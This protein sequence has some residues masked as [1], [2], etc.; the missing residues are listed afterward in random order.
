MLFDQLRRRDF[1][2]L[3]GGAAAAWPLT[4]HAQQAAMPGS[5]CSP[6]HHVTPM[7]IWSTHSAKA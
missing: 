3:F 4:V 7:A 1:I 2:T 6:S 5:D